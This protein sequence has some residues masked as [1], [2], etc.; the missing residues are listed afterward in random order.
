[1]TKP[2]FRLGGL[3][4]R[5]LLAGTASL[6]ASPMIVSSDPRRVGRRRLAYSSLSYLHAFPLDLDENR[7][8]VISDVRT[9]RHSTAIVRPVIGLGR[10]LGVPV[11]A[12]GAET[13]S[14]V[15]FVRRRV[16]RSAGVPDRPACISRGLCGYSLNH[17]GWS[18]CGRR[19][20]RLNVKQSLGSVSDRRFDRRSPR[21]KLRLLPRAPSSPPG[22]SSDPQIR[23]GNRRRVLAWR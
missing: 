18:A 4:R 22:Y 1:M 6:M 20:R 16:S 5:A 3:S 23:P 9:S 2:S 17:S 8:R 14:N 13:E 15:V 19:R 11:L 7:S 10:S 12:E 21:Q